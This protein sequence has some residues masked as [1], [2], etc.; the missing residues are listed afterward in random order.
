M[1]PRLS[2]K[3]L[4]FSFCERYCSLVWISET[5]TKLF[6]RWLHGTCLEAPAQKI[7]SED[8][9]FVFSYFPDISANPDVVSLALQ[10][11]N[12]VRS[13]ISSLTRYLM[14]WKRYRTIWKSDKVRYDTTR[15]DTMD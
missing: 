8:E 11:Q 4:D 3:A 2:T 12:G 7:D 15:Y 9:P 13:T 6:A 10:I 14:R 5:R 1:E